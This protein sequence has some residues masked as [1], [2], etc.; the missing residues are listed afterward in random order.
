MIGKKKDGYQNLVEETHVTIL[1]MLMEKC[2]YLINIDP[3]Q[4]RGQGE[5]LFN[6][7]GTLDGNKSSLG[8]ELKSFQKS[9][10]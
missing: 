8:I 4:G 5:T 3:K 9:T 7:D 6:S 2:L 10:K 1:N